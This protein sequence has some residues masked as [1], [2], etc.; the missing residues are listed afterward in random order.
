MKAT[1]QPTT[2]ERGPSI[3]DRFAEFSARYKWY[4]FAPLGILIVL[5]I[6]LAIRSGQTNAQRRAAAAALR[7][8]RTAA[9]F[10]SVT[11]KYPATFAGRLALVRAGDQL[12][13][14]GKYPEAR[15]KYTDFL[16]AKPDPL[17]A[18]PVRASVV[19]T[20]I[21]EKDY[22]AAIAECDLLAEA[23]GR[24]FALHQA[25]Y[26]KGYCYEQLGRLDDAK[27]WYEKAAPRPQNQLGTQQAYYA[28]MQR[29]WWQRST[30][31]LGEVTR[32]IDLNKEATEK[33][34]PGVSPA[35]STP[36]TSS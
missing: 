29:P 15:A 25:M 18:I 7:T 24:D 34:G 27:I 2:E 4:L 17:L 8:A 16:A 9:E 20:C 12:F 11:A 14:E 3:E 26:F 6:V 21:R 10:E 5:V 31:R 23:D 36:L 19:Q 35:V 13:R 32:L 22:T 1:K 28:A 30:E 33:P